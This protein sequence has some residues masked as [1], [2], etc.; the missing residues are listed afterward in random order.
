M[1]RFVRCWALVAPVAICTAMAAG[2]TLESVQK[3]IVEEGKKIDSMSWKS[4]YQTD[5]EYDSTKMHGEGDTTYEYMKKGEKVLYRM[6]TAYSMVTETN[7]SKQTN[8]G[9]SLMST[10]SSQFISPGPCAVK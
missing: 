7:G 5:S 8:K 6:E 9:T 4:T 3:K 10:I 2:D 1:K